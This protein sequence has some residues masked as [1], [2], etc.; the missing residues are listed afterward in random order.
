VMHIHLPAVPSRM[1]RP[2]SPR[3]NH[4]PRRLIDNNPH[5]AGNLIDGSP[6]RE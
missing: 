6:S 4:H 3:L 5:T 1:N 2:N